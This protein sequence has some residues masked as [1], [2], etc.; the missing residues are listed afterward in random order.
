[1]RHF[2]TSILNTTYILLAIIIAFNTSCSPED[3][4][5]GAQG[6][7]GQDGNANVTSVVFENQ[8][9]N[10]GNN[11]FNIPELTQDIFDH[12]MVHA[13]VTV[14]GNAYWEVLPLSLAQDIILEI[15][16]I[17]VGS[18]TVKS[19]F[20]QSNLRFRFIIVEGNSAKNEIDINKLSYEEAMTY[21]G[22][23]Y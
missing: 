7:A 16:R 19:T 6:P 11:V 14:T 12:G 13:Y 23:E 22:L 10:V 18:A 21:F 9:I 5:D 3:G 17:E 15:D 1:M 20:M 2:K 8:T 4:K